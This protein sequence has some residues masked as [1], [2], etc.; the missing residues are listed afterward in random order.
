ME[1][2]ILT[3]PKRYN[4]SDIFY[5]FFSDK[6]AVCHDRVEI[7]FLM[8]VIS[9]EMTVTENGQEYSVRKGQCVFIRRDHRITFSKKLYGDEPFASITLRFN[10]SYLRKFYQNLKIDNRLKNAKPLQSSIYVLPKSPY[11]DS[12]FISMLPFFESETQPHMDMIE[13]KMQEGVLALL[14]L[15]ESFYPTLF[16][17]ADPWKVDILDFLNE[18]YMHE[19]SLEEIA[20][21]TGRSLATFKRDFAKVSEL[22]PQKWLINKRLQKAYDMIAEQGKSVTEACYDVGFKNRSHFTTAFK[23]QYGVSPNN[24][25][26]KV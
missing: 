5:S 8:Y 14:N 22:T 9:G 12:L 23:R 17:F 2:N 6:E 10:R 15:D 19:L 3:S 1:N 16:D 26:V 4:Y 21:Y 24:L 13:Q 18:N 11:L 25:H 20:S 7:H